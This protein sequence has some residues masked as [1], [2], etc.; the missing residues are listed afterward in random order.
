MNHNFAQ[1]TFSACTIFVSLMLTEWNLKILTQSSN[2]LS[3]TFNY[4]AVKSRCFFCVQHIYFSSLFLSVL[5]L[6]PEILVF[7]ILRTFFPSLSLSFPW[8][9]LMFSKICI[10]FLWICVLSTSHGN[11]S[12]SLFLF[13]IYSIFIIVYKFIS[14]SNQVVSNRRLGIMSYLWF[15]CSR[16]SVKI[17][18]TDLLLIRLI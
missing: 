2:Y 13:F 18:W 4:S 3:H 16:I 10:F 9:F 5:L 14:S 12:Y 11:Y 7:P 17:Y 6:S 8:S 15:A 1:D